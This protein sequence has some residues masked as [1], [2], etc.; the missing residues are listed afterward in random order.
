MKA[1]RPPWRSRSPRR[2]RGLMRT[3]ADSFASRVIAAAA[4]PARPWL[5]ITVS[6]RVARFLVAAGA[7]PAPARRGGNLRN[8]A[9][10]GADLTGAD[11][12]RA[13]LDGADL[14]GADLT[15]AILARADLGGAILARAN[16]GGAILVGAILARADLHAATLDG[17]DLGDAT[18]DGADL[19]DATLIGANLTGADLAGATLGGADLTGMLWSVHTEWPGAMAKA[20]KARSEEVRPGIWRVVGSGTAD[21]EID[22]PLTPAG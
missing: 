5:H 9:W 2:R 7:R 18:L 17:A 21:A 11:L 12:R 6:S 20:M 1:D 4:R 8:A 19:G 13:D 15:G 14:T 10:S 16:L 3:R 22:A